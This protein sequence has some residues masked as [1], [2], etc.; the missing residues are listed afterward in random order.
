M[1]SSYCYYYYYDDYD[2]SAVLM[3]DSKTLCTPLRVEEHTHH[4]AVRC[5]VLI[6]LVN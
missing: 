3:L 2:Y 1:I 6:E 4:V 5:P